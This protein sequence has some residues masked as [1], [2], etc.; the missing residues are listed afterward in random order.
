VAA[1]R[2]AYLVVRDDDNAQRR[3]FLPLKNNVGNDQSGLAFELREHQLGSGIDTCRV[4]WETQ[5]VSVTADQALAVQHGDRS[6][7][8]EAKAFLLDALAAGKAP[9]AEIE[10]DADG[11][12]I[13]KSTLRRAKQALGV[14]AV[15]VGQP[16]KPD[17]PGKWF[18]R[19]PDAPKALK[20]PEDAQEES[21]STFEKHEHL[22]EPGADEVA[23]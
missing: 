19:M 1:A 12:G 9:S 21:M 23:V 11:N 3:L 14:Q 13:S 20:K 8:D 15:K 7:L 18:W 6:E 22:R 4:L 17:S 10:R 16:G 5:P 2:A